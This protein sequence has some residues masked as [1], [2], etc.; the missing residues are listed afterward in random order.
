MNKIIMTISVLLCST[1]SNLSYALPKTIDVNQIN[2]IFLNRE[3]NPQFMSYMTQK[4]R[5]GLFNQIINLRDKS[6][7]KGSA[8]GLR[9]IKK[10]QSAAKVIQ[11][12]V[13]EHIVNCKKQTML[14]TS[15]MYKANGELILKSNQINQKVQDDIKDTVNQAC[16]K[17]RLK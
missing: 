16:I 8:I 17:Q 6:L 9:V 14:M 13:Q 4:N 12:E 11:Y 15:G 1:I 2:Q 5:D 7:D 3:S 10:N